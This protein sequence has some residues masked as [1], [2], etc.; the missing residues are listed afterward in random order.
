MRILRLAVWPLAAIAVTGCD[1]A[2]TIGPPSVAYGNSVC[3]QCNMIISDERFAAAT[4]IDGPRGRT[5]MLFDDYNCQFNF[6]HANPELAILDRWAHDHA[7]LAWIPAETAVYV[8]SESIRSPMASRV[9]AFADR[10]GADALVHELGD[11][12]VIRFGQLSEAMGI[13]GGGHPEP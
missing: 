6:E 12:A 2:E 8:H 9:A 5:A 10:A 11:G 7:T 3:D 1:R 4:F 13:S